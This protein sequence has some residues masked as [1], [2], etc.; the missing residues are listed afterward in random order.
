MRAILSPFAAVGPFTRDST[1]D[2]I[3]VLA[4]FGFTEFTRN[5]FEKHPGL[6]SKD[7]S[8]ILGFAAD[9]TCNGVELYAG[10]GVD[11]VYEGANLTAKTATELA[12]TCA[13]LELEAS[14]QDY[15]LSCPALGIATFHPNFEIQST[16]A[17]T[18]LI[19]QTYISLDPNYVP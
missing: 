1:F 9:G 4:E 8:I 6:I 10:C 12:E 19:D 15:G 13:R 11:L 5:Q 18:D 2:Q 14:R 16:S 3:K 7:R 17:D